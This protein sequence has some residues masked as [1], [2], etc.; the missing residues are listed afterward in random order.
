LLITSTPLGTA[1]LIGTLL[2][3]S[4]WPPYFDLSEREH[5]PYLGSETNY[6]DRDL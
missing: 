6:E 1:T 5:N 2:F 4:A 3:L